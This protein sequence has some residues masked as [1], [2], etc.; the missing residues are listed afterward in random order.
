LPPAVQYATNPSHPNAVRNL[1]NGDIDA[2]LELVG[3]IRAENPTAN[4]RWLTYDR[5]TS[6]DQLTGHVVLLGGLDEGMTNTL[7][8][9]ADLVQAFFRALNLPAQSHWP[10]DVGNEFDGEFVVHLDSDGAPTSDPEKTERIES[11]RPR[12]LRDEAQPDRPR[13]LVRGAPQLTSDVALVVRAP[14]PA[15]PNATLTLIGGIF[16]RGTYAAVRAFTDAQFRARNEQW[17]HAALDPKNFWILV[18][19]TILADNTMTPDLTRPAI[20]LRSS[21]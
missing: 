10:S 6:A 21:A 20:R 13:L 15:N 17:L 7:V 9:T 1:G 3:H 19:I 14:N 8:G 12:F 4:V 18:Q 16:S 5:V 2:L 11:Y